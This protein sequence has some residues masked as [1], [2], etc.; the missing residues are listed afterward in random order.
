MK[1][2]RG[3]GGTLA[4]RWRDFAFIITMFWAVGLGAWKVNPEVPSIA[5]KHANAAL[6]RLASLGSWG[7]NPGNIQ[8][9]ILTNFCR[10]KFDELIVKLGDDSAAA[11][12]CIRPQS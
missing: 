10:H 3:V 5:K 4:G 9:E 1:A 2:W 7:R 6:E 12:Y 8:R 11:K